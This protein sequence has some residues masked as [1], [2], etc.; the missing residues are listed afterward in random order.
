MANATAITINDL[1]RDSSIAAPTA[2]VMDTGTAAVAVDTPA[3]GG[4]TGRIIVVVTN[5]AANNLTVVVSAGD[6]PPAHRAPLGAYTT[7]N[8]AQNGVRVLGPFESSRFGK[9]GKL[10]LTFTPASGTIACNFIAYRLPK[11]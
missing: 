6:N 3:L 8:I 11:A 1:A 10:R 7:P 4:D 9:G 5:T 2:Q